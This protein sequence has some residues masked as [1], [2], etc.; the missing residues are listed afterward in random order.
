[1][2]LN[3][4]ILIGRIG[5]DPEIRY[6]GAGDPI[7]NFSLATT[8]TWKKDGQK[9]EKT[10]WHRV[11]AFGQTAKFVQDYLGKGRLVF[12][13]GSIQYSEYTDRE[14]NKRL[15]VSIK[16][17]RVNAL[18]YK[19]DESDDQVERAANDVKEI[20]GTDDSESVPF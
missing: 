11:A 8:E 16:A 19:R 3:K 18:D 20:F 15:S 1:M 13:E 2:N 17:Q 12:V 10:E 14:G 7:A 4:V 9:Q 5:K 6:S